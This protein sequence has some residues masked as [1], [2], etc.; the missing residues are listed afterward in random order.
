MLNALLS[1]RANER[2][3]DHRSVSSFVTTAVLRIGVFGTL[4]VEF[5]LH[6][7][8]WTMGVYFLGFFLPLG[9]YAG[10]VN[11]TPLLTEGGTP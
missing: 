1:M 4:P 2:L 7:P 3:L 10:T 8:W 11:R 5:A 9:L 6:G